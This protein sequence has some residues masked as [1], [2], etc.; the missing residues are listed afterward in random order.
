MVNFL[1]KLLRH[2]WCS[3]HQ[4]RF[5]S[6]VPESQPRYLF[7][8]PELQPRLLPSVPGPSLPL[9]L[10]ELPPEVKAPAPFSHTWG[11]FQLM[12]V[13]KRKVSRS[14]KGIRNG[15][16]ALKPQPVIVRCKVCGR[17]KL[18]HFYCCSGERKD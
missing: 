18:P 4:S 5:F 16:K 2:S 7:S 10:L 17:V 11:V 3:H 8:I 12:A 14:K 15:P 6:S 9:Q 1:Q 13:P